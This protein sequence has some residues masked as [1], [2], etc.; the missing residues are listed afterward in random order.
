MNFDKESISGKKIFLA[1]R[2][3]GGGGW[4]VGGRGGS[5]VK[6]DASSVGK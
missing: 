6:K 5:V 2:E 1:A 3:V 4:G